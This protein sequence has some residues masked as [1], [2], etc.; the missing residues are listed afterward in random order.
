MLPWTARW[1]QFAFRTKNWSRFFSFD[2]KNSRS[3]TNIFKLLKGRPWPKYKHINR[4]FRA[5]FSLLSKL[6]WGCK[7]LSIFTNN[8]NEK[9]AHIKS[10]RRTQIRAAGSKK[11]SILHVSPLLK[12]ARNGTIFWNIIRPTLVLT[13]KLANWNYNQVF[14][15]VSKCK[16]LQNIE[17][18]HMQILYKRFNITLLHDTSNLI[19]TQSLHMRIKLQR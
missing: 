7:F 2:H 1:S 9:H 16:A 11:N 6:I 15:I 8:H 10:S 14:R 13:Y 3:A 17:T 18:Y 5:K 12:I 19:Q 4:K